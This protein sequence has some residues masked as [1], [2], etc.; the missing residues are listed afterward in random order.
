MP[1]TVTVTDELGDHGS[2]LS[3]RWSQ[4]GSSGGGGGGWEMKIFSHSI[5]LT[6][7]V[8]LCI[9]SIQGNSKAD[10]TSNTST[11]LGHVPHQATRVDCST[12][13]PVDQ[14]V[15]IF[16]ACISAGDLEGAGTCARICVRQQVS[17]V[18]VVLQLGQK[19]VSRG[20]VVPAIELYQDA[21]LS[22]KN[23]ANLL[24][25]LGSAMGMIDEWFNS[26]QSFRAAIEKDFQRLIIRG[27]WRT[28]TQCTYLSDILKK[29]CCHR[30]RIVA[31]HAPPA[32]A[33]EGLYLIDITPCAQACVVANLTLWR[34]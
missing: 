29:L 5:Y 13:I 30:N 18:A 2:E 6:M 15:K 23:D 25:N 8:L 16:H 4:A 27:F 12:Q 31:R 32:M 14:N 22:A 26:S 1:V 28:G 17:G 33:Y 10:N 7:T 24:F 9:N 21:L 11:G 3:P 19:L 20:L 34:S